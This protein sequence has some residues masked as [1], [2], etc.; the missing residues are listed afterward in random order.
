M[1]AIVE[2]E[3]WQ[4]ELLPEGTLIGTLGGDRTIIVSSVCGYTHN[5]GKGP[6]FHGPSDSPIELDGGISVKA[7]P[8][9]ETTNPLLDGAV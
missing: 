5:Q 4:C 1:T 7:K 8:L 9:P 3:S 2:C 6:V